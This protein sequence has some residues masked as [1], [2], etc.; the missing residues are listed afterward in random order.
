MKSKQNTHQRW[1]EAAYEQFADVGPDQ[2]N[3]KAL[4]RTA[5]LPRTN[6]YYYFHDKEDL[7][8]QL[9]KAHIDLSLVYE[10]ELK[11]K[12]KV[13]IP[14]FYDILVAFK[15]GIKFHWQLFQH[16]QDIRFAHIYNTLNRSSNKFIVPRVKEYFQLDI[17]ES[18]VEAIWTTL[19]DLWYARLDFENYNSR[20]LSG[21][22]ED[23]MQ[24]LLE[25]TAQVTRREIAKR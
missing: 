21:L 17:P 6:F 12:L 5:G 9:L 4:T 8:Q 14:D 10:L 24:T 1:L 16:K 15:T 2:L 13:L 19:I 11:K 7:I 20:S 3:V 23:I 22:T 25:F 18:S